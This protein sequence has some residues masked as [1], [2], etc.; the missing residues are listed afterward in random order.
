MF[1]SMISSTLTPTAFIICLLS[2]L[3]LGL[4]VSLTYMFR[5]TCSKSFATTLA[6]LP[7][8]VAV[9]IMMVS[10]NLGAGVAVAGTFSLV[11]FRSAP[12]TA[13]EICAIFLSMAIGLACG[14][15]YIGFA[16]LF[17]II[18]CG[19]DVLYNSIHFGEKKCYNKYN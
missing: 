7:A 14:M 15:G 19:V 2:A 4:A 16:A 6:M 11:R 9:I 8:M 12:G 3:V 10:G 5:S 13:R 17:A 1:N 18:L